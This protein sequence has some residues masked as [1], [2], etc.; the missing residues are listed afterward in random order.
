MQILALSCIV[1]M[2][3]IGLW[4]SMLERKQYNNGI[5]KQT[6]KPWK[7]FDTDSQGGRGYTSGPYTVWISWPG[8]D[9]N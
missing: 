1:I 9:K 2:L 5:C 6:G 8:I 3:V 7:Y 4:G